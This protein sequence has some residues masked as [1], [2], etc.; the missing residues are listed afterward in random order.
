VFDKNGNVVIDSRSGEPIATNHAHRDFFQI[1]KERADAGLYISRPWVSFRGRYLISLSRRLSN[2]DG[3]FA[4]VV[5]GTMRLSYF[6]DQFRKVNLSENDTLTLINGKG[7][8]LMRSPFKIDS[9]GMDIGNTSAWKNFPAAESGWYETASAIDGIK[10]VYTF[11]RIGE[12]P[13]LVINGLSL[14]TIYAGWWQEALLI[15]SLIFALC[16]VNIAL[17]VSL[18]REL[19]RRTEAEHELA[20]IATTDSLTGLCNRRRLD[21][22]VAS[23]WSRARRVHSP[24]AMLMIDVDC[25]KAYN[26]KHGHQAGDRALTAVAECIAKSANRPADLCARYGGEEFAVLLPGET[27]E[28]AFEIA[29]RIRGTVLSLRVGQ[30]QT[31]ETIP[32]VSVGAASMVPYAGLTPCDLI[33]AADGALYEAKR[34]GRNR[35]EVATSIQFVEPR[36][37]LV[38][39]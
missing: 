38:A 30:P 7:V 4:G 28:G 15:G 2:P 39:V 37:E 8:V 26:D 17:I 31:L 19:R 24:I 25:F 18:T 21:V 3:S 5:A 22:V 29:E 6:H 1:H 20:V 14:D 12:Y 34:N 27:V 23:E 35:T 11:Q 9:I 10:R 16:A 33:K 13:L 32:T 36:P